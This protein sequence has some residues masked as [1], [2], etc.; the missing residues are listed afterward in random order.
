MEMKELIAT[1]KVINE[2]INEKNTDMKEN[3][4]LLKSMKLSEEV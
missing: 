4:L 1:M 3:L 2:K